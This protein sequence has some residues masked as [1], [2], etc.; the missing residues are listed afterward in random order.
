MK[1]CR[2]YVV[3]VASNQVYS[4]VSPSGAQSS[5]LP[6]GSTYCCGWSSVKGGG[7]RRQMK[8]QLPKVKL[9]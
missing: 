3:F 1:N 2:L 8:S 9:G 7:V 6:T 4:F 5:T